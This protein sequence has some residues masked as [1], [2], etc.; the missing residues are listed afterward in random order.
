MKKRAS[1]KL[2]TKRIYYGPDEAPKKKA[3]GP[4][5]GGTAPPAVFSGRSR[6]MAAENFP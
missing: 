6:D 1:R 3:R 5:F 2:R 4:M